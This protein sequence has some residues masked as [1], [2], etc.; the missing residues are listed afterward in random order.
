MRGAASSYWDRQTGGANAL[1]FESTGAFGFE[2][3]PNTGVRN[4]ATWEN[5]RSDVA[6]LDC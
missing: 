3:I 2:T 1:V 6:I 5:D 4:V